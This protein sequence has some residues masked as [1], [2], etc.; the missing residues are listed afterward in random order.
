MQRFITRL[1]N[2]HHLWTHNNVKSI[3]TITL[4][5][6]L[7]L[8][9]IMVVACS[10]EENSTPTAA[11]S[12][13]SPT[14]IV[15]TPAPTPSPTPDLE[16]VSAIDVDP[17]HLD[18]LTLDFWHVW[19][20]EAGGLMQSLVEQFNTSN[21]LGI[22]VQPVYAGN[23]NDLDEKF[24][25][26]A[27]EGNYPNLI[28]GF[29]YQILTWEIEQPH[30]VDLSTYTE[31]PVWGF[32][33]ADRDDFYHQ[34]WE[35]E[36][37]NET[38]IGIPFHRSAHLM[39]YNASW[40]EELG[41][42]SPPNNPQEFK[43]QVCA[44]TRANTANPNIRS[45]T[46]GWV[47][48]TDPSAIL[49][50]I[51]A[52]G[53]NVVSF[54]N[55]S[56]D[57]ATPEIEDAFTYLKDLYDDGCAWQI[58]DQ[59][60]EV[61]FA[62]RLALVITA[63]LVD[64]PY[65]VQAMQYSQNDDTWMVLGFPSVDNQQSISVYGPSLAMLRSSNEEQLASW[66]FMKWLVSPEVQAQWVEKTGVFPVRAS[67]LEHLAAFTAENPQW[68]AAAELLPHARSEPSLP[69]WS[70]V[71]WAVSDVGTQTFRYYFEASRIPDMLDLLDSTAAELHARFE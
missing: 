47:T 69:S 17:A 66:I 9:T 10:D 8:L 51:Y 56:Y 48:N 36:Q 11:L 45:G 33:T 18:G 65:I 4:L 43:Q 60:A 53:G 35:Q 29:N 31:D 41:F 27:G 50:W 23:Y 42:N 39:I 58:E 63:S 62:E 26:L 52:F 70:I 25:Q 30:V 28:I 46:G 14:S 67:T 49:S 21:E 59:Y 15:I 55:K 1:G 32:N 34:I 20:G 22:H 3:K 64:L 71:R 40:A 38:R 16:P 7:L 2:F 6:T 44:A 13:P 24:Q 37:H 5:L 57:F 54:E 19:S 61:E 68:A 12:T